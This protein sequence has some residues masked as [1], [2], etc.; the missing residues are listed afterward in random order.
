MRLQSAPRSSAER[1]HRRGPARC[2]LVPGAVGLSEDS[3]S[4][5][6][7]PAGRGPGQRAAVTNACR[8][9]S[10]TLVPPGVF[11]AAD[12]LPPSSCL[13]WPS[14][15]SGPN[16]GCCRR[17]LPSP[18]CP[19]HPAL[20]LPRVGLYEQL[21][22]EAGP[23][24]RCGVWVHSGDSWPR[25]V[26]LLPVHLGELGARPSAAL[27]DVLT[28]GLYRSMERGCAATS[29]TPSLAPVGL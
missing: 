6:C 17:L 1:A 27:A 9:V 20:L 29:C 25:Q 3:G 18:S 16:M 2:P 15:S 8:Q 10:S 11:R 22:T 12:E 24:Q 28:C 7:P 5:E 23:G 13:L 4:G 19:F 14:C 21:L 26:R